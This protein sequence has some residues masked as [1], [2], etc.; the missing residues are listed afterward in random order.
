MTVAQLHELHY[1]EL[2]IDRHDV[3]NRIP[4]GLRAHFPNSIQVYQNLSSRLPGKRP[5]ARTYPPVKRTVTLLQMAGSPATG[6]LTVEDLRQYVY[7]AQQTN[8][9]L[10]Y[11]KFGNA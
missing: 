2:P 11:W 3:W 7:G 8:K 9:A 1:G 10:T 6:R 4:W 5:I